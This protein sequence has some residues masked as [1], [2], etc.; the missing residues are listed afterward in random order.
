M[1]LEE[2]LLGDDFHNS[3]LVIEFEDLLM[4]ATKRNNLSGH[5]NK[6]QYRTRDTELPRVR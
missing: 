2:S 1:D 6:Y 5:S 3:S 4:I